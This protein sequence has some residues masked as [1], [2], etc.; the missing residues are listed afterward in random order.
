M[1]NDYER[2]WGLD[3]TNASSRDPF[4]LTS[5]LATGTLSYTRRFMALRGF[6]YTVWTWTDLVTWTQDP[7]AVQTSGR[8][9]A[10]VETGTVSLSPALLT[11]PRLFVR[12]CATR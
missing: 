2:L 12:M 8:P 4:R 1:S 9:V 7:G 3:P 11:G 10:E 5:G 6:N